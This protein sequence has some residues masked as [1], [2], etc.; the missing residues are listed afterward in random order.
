MPTNKSSPFW[1]GFISA[2]NIFPR[3]ESPVYKDDAEAFAADQK[4]LEGDW[5]KIENDFNEASNK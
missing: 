2:F 5:A 3:D 4:A 1:K